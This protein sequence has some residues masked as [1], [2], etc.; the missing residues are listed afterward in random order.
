MLLGL[1]F[2]K[3]SPGVLLAINLDRREISRYSIT[4]GTRVG[5][6]IKL[7]DDNASLFGVTHTNEASPTFYTND[8]AKAVLYYR[9]EATSWQTT[10]NPVGTA[11]RGM[12][13]DG[14]DFWI[15]TYNPA[16]GLCRFKPGASAALILIP[17][18]SADPSGLT[19]FPYGGNTCIAIVSYDL[20][21]MFIYELNGR[22]L[23]YIGSATLPMA[24][25]GDICG[26]TYCD[27]NKNFYLTYENEDED[28]F[29]AEVSFTITSLARS[30]WG[31][32]KTSF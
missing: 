13:F 15:T 19:V 3:G 21:E 22:E 18:V 32:I 31:S 29:I 14:T 24:D 9:K 11:G 5:S 23:V 20:D 17:D 7:H 6:G 16:P 10:P 1:D 2:L 27:T 12:D 26:L 25:M 28:Y 4:D 8:W 30:S